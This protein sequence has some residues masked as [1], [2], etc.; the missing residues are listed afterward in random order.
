[1]NRNIAFPLY[2]N[3]ISKTSGTQKGM[4][5]VI[6]SK[7]RSWQQYCSRSKEAKMA[8]KTISGE[9]RKTL[10]EEYKN[11]FVISYMELRRTIG[12]VGMSMPFILIV[13]AWVFF[14]IGLQISLSAYYDTPMR[15]ISVGLMFFLSGFLWSYRGYDR[16]DAIAGKLA[17]IF[18]LLSVIFPLP[19]DPAQLGIIGG[20][21]NILA[22]LFFL[23]LIYFSG[24]LFTKSRTGTPVT[25]QKLLRN[26]IYR[27]C[28]VMMGVSLVVG[29]TLHFTPGFASF[30]PLLWGETLATEAFGIAWFV[31]GEGI[32]KDE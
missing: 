28:A 24:Y 27:V 3:I 22:G 12:I 23:T 32:L 17:S 21:H 31:K 14:S 1:M 5:P 6:P 19:K 18:G 11:D 30:R 20:L 10:G 13:G 4:T 25:P 2:S 26:R 15:D 7:M 16:R 9:K 8:R 29:L